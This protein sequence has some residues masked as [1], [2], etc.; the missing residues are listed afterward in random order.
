MGRQRGQATVEY[1]GVGLLVLVLL[2][3]ATATARAELAAPPR[4]DAAQ[5]AAAARYTPMLALEHGDDVERPVDFRTCRAV[6]CAGARAR[7]VLFTH[8]VHTGGFIYYEYWEYLP[9]SRFAH[10]G[11]PPID[12]FHKDDWEGVIVKVRPGG[13]VVGARASAHLGFTGRHPWWDLA[14]N[15]W[16]PYP[17]T[18]YRASGSHAGGFA[19]GGIDLS[20]DRWNGTAATV[21]PAL[22]AAD[23][24]ESAGAAFDPGSVPP[25]RKQVWTDPEAVIT[26][27]PGDHA[28]YARYA[29]WWADA[30]VV[31]RFVE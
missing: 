20:G 15:D 10:T 31:C 13:S 8:V 12:G 24:A 28:S 6:A 14:A 23:E 21:R 25:W 19:P 3:L 2:G 27:H 18:V 11:I 7:A 17:A 5:L 4:G 9:D 30:C 22:V 1:L 29:R 26:G 16:A